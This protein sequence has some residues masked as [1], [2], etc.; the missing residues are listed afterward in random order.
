[1]ESCNTPTY[2][3]SPVPIYDKVELMDPAQRPLKTRSKEEEE[4]VCVCVWCVRACV[5]CVRACVWYVRVCVCGVCGVCVCV[6]CVC[7]CACVCMW[8]VLA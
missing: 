6:V 1:M 2:V 5:W 4:E 7:L 3:N 8:C